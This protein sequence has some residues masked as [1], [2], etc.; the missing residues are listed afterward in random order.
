MLPS[1]NN[2][3]VSVSTIELFSKNTLSPPASPNIGRNENE[4]ISPPQEPK[5]Q[6]K[7]TTNNTQVPP[8]PPDNPI[9]DAEVTTSQAEVSLAACPVCDKPFKSVNR[10]MASAHPEEHKARRAATVSKNTN[11]KSPMTEGTKKPNPQANS[12]PPGQDGPSRG[13][14]ENMDKC[15]ECGG[16]YRHGAGMNNH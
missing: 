1:I 10:H 2:D 5:R 11:A 8:D 7:E 14:F 9:Y 15:G 16:L 3:T 6:D 12:Q 13:T 4:D